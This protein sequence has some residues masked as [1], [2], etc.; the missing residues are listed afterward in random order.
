MWLVLC[1]FRISLLFSSWRVNTLV[2]RKIETGGGVGVWW[3][4]GSMNIYSPW[5]ICQFSTTITT[6]YI[7]EH[8]Y[9]QH[10]H[11]SQ[12]L[13]Q[14]L[15]LHHTTHNTTTTNCHLTMFLKCCE[16]V[17]M[18]CLKLFSVKETFWNEWGIAYM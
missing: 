6:Q 11:Y 13:T 4:K 15:K 1:L 12:H 5:Y 16:L 2:G 8:Y 14:T 10:N 17:M 9:N 7:Y 18:K 3:E